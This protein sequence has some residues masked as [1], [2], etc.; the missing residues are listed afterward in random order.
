MPAEMVVALQCGPAFTADEYNDLVARAVTRLDHDL[1]C[2][3]LG[4]SAS[5][6]GER[7]LATVGPSARQAVAAL[8]PRLTARRPTTPWAGG[9]D[10]E[11]D[12]GR[13]SLKEILDGDDETGDTIEARVDDVLTPSGFGLRVLAVAHLRARLTELQEQ[14]RLITPE[15]T[16]QRTPVSRCYDDGG[17]RVIELCDLWRARI[18]ADRADQAAAAQL[19]QYFETEQTLFDEWERSRRDAAAPLLDHILRVAATLRR[20]LQLLL[21]ADLPDRAH[22]ALRAV[23][24]QID[25]DVHAL[26]AQVS[27]QVDAARLALADVEV[28][29]EE[30]IGR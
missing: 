16:A 7:L 23:F 30:A 12:T 15:V 19:R 6:Y 18:L 21:D 28:G 1:E 26:T 4:P 8:D 13:Q 9:D 17:P 27:E 3:L 22:P 10:H 20:A 14:L 29:V 2:G 5:A 11:W 25:F 24:E